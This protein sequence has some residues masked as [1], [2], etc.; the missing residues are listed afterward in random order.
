MHIEILGT[1]GEIPE[2]APYH[3]RQSGVLIDRQLMLDVG[4][5][6]FLSRHP[7]WI[8]LTHLHPDHAYFVR[9]GTA[10]TVP[11]YGPEQSPLAPIRLLH[12]S[13][14]LGPYT[15]TPIPT[16]HSK[17]VKSQAY[18]V[19]RGHRSLLYTGDLI[20]IEKRYHSLIGQVDLVITEASFLRT[21]GLIRRDATTG[22]P[23]GHTGIPNL[24]HLLKR[25][26]SH[27]LLTHFGSWFYADTRA[28]RRK[29][30]AL[31][32]QQAIQL[33]VGYDGM[34]LDI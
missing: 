6:R 8:L 16:I 17:R 14:R 2:T 9:G 20:W 24:I 18:L 10:P 32:R 21:G 12:S 26:S 3:S 5:A 22:L 1:R 30:Q 19:K 27:L 29:L 11:L 25:F 33:T 34:I 28:A 13:R 15:I 7:R 23:Y 4:D 31:A